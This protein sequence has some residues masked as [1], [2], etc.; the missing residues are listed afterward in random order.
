MTD[1]KVPQRG[2]RSSGNVLE[3]TQMLLKGM[4]L[5][6]VADNFNVSG[7]AIRKALKYAGLPTQSRSLLACLPEGC[8]PTDAAILRSANHKLAAENEDLK[9]KIRG[10]KSAAKYINAIMKEL[11]A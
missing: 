6:E 11:S 10:L 3:Y 8:T 7:S 2:N 4:T 5:Q 9:R 1:N